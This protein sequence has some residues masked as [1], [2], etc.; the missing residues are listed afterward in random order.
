MITKRTFTAG[1]LGGVFALAAGIAAP[2]VVLAQD[3][4][5]YP[6]QPIQ[7]IVPFAPG[8]ASDFAARLL[9]NRLAEI[10]GQ[11]VVIVNRDGAA[12][13]IGMG[14]AARAKPD[15]YT[16]FLGNVGTVSINPHLFSDLKVKPLEDF[17]PISIV[18]DTPGLLISRPD[19]PAKDAK[20]FVEY[21]KQN[22]GKVNFASPGTGSVNRLEMESLALEQ[23]LKMTHIPY[24]GGAGP[25]AADVM[26]GH[27]DVMF[28]TIATAINNVKAGRLKALAVTTK[29]RVPSLPDLPTMME[30]GLT[31][32]PSSSWQGILVP[33][34]TP[35]P[36][37][38]K[39][40]SAVVETMK[41]KTIHER[42]A[43]SGVLAVSSPSP[44][45]FTDYIKADSQQ[46]S[47]VIQKGNIKAD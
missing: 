46:W 28:V 35:K 19:F 13:N 2:K 14:L 47:S 30:Q 5:N 18:A 12:G 17:I 11:Q 4:S 26:G 33:A 32:R 24:K 10:L 7:I 27:V 42:M 21:V 40:H 25:A 6:N 31:T 9:Q 37:V 45:A 22:P 8:G 29:E 20:E 16:L 23:G 3:A 15:G 1:L 39:I 34:G 41:D 44:A 36:I 38:D 43:A